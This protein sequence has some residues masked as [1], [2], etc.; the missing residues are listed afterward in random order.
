MSDETKARRIAQ[1]LLSDEEDVRFYQ[2]DALFRTQV[3]L[4]ARGAVATMG[5][6][7]EQAWQ[8]GV[9]ERRALRA[10]RHGVLSQMMGMA[11]TEEGP[12]T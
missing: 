2:N 4:I 1:A 8:R 7:I 10:A 6:L 9:E 5:P 3:D 11:P 12:T